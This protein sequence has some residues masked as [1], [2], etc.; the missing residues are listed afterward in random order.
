VPLDGEPFDLVV[1]VAALQAHGGFP[2]ALAALAG[3]TRPGG[4][5][6][7][8]EGYWAE[9]PSPSFLE[10]LGGATADEVPLGIDALLLA[11]RAV[12]LEPERHAVASPADWGAYEEGLA[13]NAEALGTQDGLTYARRIRE[14]R[15]LPGGTTTLGFALLTLRRG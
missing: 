12:G 2:R 1:N 13:A 5:V 6:L 10:A 15:A 4:I 14:R 8:G 3:L 9:E 11:G 7:Y